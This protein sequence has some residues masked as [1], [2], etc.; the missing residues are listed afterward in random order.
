MRR[1]L[2]SHGCG[3]A[4]RHMAR[5]LKRH[6]RSRS[7]GKLI[8]SIVRG[9]KR[10][11]TKVPLRR[12]DKFVFVINDQFTNAPNTTQI[13]SGAGHSSASGSNAAI[14]SP[15]TDQQVSVGAGGTADNISILREPAHAC[16]GK[17]KRSRRRKKEAI[18]VLNHQ[19]VQM[20]EG[21]EEAA[22]TQIASGSGTHSTSGT[23]STIDSP[24]TRQQDSVGGGP[25]AS[26]MNKFVKKKKRSH[27][28]RRHY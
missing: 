1:Y 20:P 26:G 15:N 8:V 3:Y 6:S 9:E 27:H 16:R 14:G 12:F 4:R 21:S 13:A 7:Q 2:K 17:R 5:R 24:C 18:F 19:R 23:N 22:A 11:T 10:L 28:I 25:G